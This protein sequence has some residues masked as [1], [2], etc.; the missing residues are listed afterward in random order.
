MCSTMRVNIVLA[1]CYLVGLLLFFAQTPGFDLYSHGFMHY[2]YDEPYLGSYS[3]FEIQVP[4]YLLLSYSYSFGRMIGI[5]LGWIAFIIWAVPM[6]A[7]YMYLQKCPSVKIGHLI[8]WF[9]VF[10]V[11]VKFSSMSIGLIWLIS[12]YL[13]GKR[14]LLLGFFFHP[15]LL[16][17]LPLFFLKIVK[18]LHL[19]FLI[20]MFFLVAVLNYFNNTYGVIALDP[21]SRKGVTFDNFFQIL[22]LA[23]R[24][25]EYLFVAVFSIFLFNL[26]IR[27]KNGR[28]FIKLLPILSLFSVY[29]F[30]ILFDKSAGIVALFGSQYEYLSMTWID[31]GT[32]DYAEYDKVSLRDLRNAHNEN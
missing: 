14:Y 16:I 22:H 18:N 12:Y 15:L 24:K 27:M 4:R 10:M 21:S 6:H 29:G 13:V 17:I 23:Q 5:P 31:F 2:Y 8:T 11:A 7:V 30:V 28:I 9:F 20:K 25:I 1:Y 3:L 26:G 19:Y 32:R